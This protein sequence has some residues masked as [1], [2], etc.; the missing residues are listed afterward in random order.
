MSQRPVGFAVFGAGRIGALHAYNV[1][2][3]TPGAQLIGVADVDPAAAQRAIRATE[4][5]RATT[6][7]RTLLEDPAVSA[8][9]IATPTDSHAMLMVEAANH[10][11]HV[12]C[13][14]PVAQTLAATCA[15]MEAVAASGV[16]VQVGFNRRFDPDF[17]QAHAA[18]R[19]GDIG[20]P[21]IVRL[22]G[23]DPRIAPIS[24]LKLSGGQFKDQ[25]I[26]EYDMA[27]WLAGCE[28]DE[29][30]AIGSVLVDPELRELGDVDTS[31][32]TLRYVS[33]ALG[34]IDS[35]RKAV[36]GYDVRAEVHGSEG[37]LFIGGQGNPGVTIFGPDQAAQEQVAFF[38]DRF[39]D[40]FRAE[41][42]HFVSCIQT[43]E[44]PCVGVADGYA[45][46]QIA[47]AAGRSLHERRPV[48]IGE[49]TSD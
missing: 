19:R 48:R 27:R 23:R 45:A 8:V 3:H 6:D 42:V 17:A 33:G 1:A 49:V 37:T 2:R 5:G 12:L 18:I 26:H 43:G 25:A 22:V 16:L 9:I 36:H 41:L 32:T 44:P 4:Q 7:Y 29:V 15:A 24:Y 35:C 20:D 34:M 21:W 31:I 47:V 11:K 39:A 40:A 46:L 30:S 13:E 28:V 14:K 38:I 10:G